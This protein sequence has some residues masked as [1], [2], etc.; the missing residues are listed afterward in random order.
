MLW[1]KPF[2]IFDCNLESNTYITG[3]A[4]NDQGGDITRKKITFTVK[5]CHHSAMVMERSFILNPR[6]LVH[7]LV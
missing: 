2:N 4:F 7:V 3:D 5:S 1:D 6:N